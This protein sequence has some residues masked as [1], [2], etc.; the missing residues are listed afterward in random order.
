MIEAVAEHSADADALL[1]GRVTFEQIPIT[2]WASKRSGAKPVRLTSLLVFIAGSGLAGAAW[3]IGALI[4]FRVAQGSGTGM[5]LPGRPLPAPVKPRRLRRQ[6]VNH[7]HDQSQVR[8]GRTGRSAM[9]NGKEDIA[10]FLAEWAQAELTGNTAVLDGHLVEDFVGVGPLGFLLPKQAWLNR[11]AQGLSY[12]EFSLEET[13]VRRYG[14]TA[15]VVGKQNQKGSMGSNPLPFGAVRATLV[16][17]NQSGAWRLAG[18]HYS[19]IAGAPGAPPV[20]G[21]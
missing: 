4:A 13:Q 18:V 1:V 5:I 12:D 16:L 19:F 17:L 6:V 2:D 11:F 10:A 9:S 8:T 20:P 3:S 15:V 7:S 21:Q 14:D